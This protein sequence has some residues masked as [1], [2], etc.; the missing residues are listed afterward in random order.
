MYKYLLTVNPQLKLE[1][2]SI[3]LASAEHIVIDNTIHFLD[4][5]NIHFYYF[6]ENCSSKILFMENFIFYKIHD[7]IKKKKYFYKF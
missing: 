7:K 3:Y 6:V 2:V 5:K 4:R 1:I